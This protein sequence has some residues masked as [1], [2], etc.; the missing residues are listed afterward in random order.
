[1]KARVFLAAKTT[2]I[3][4]YI[5]PAK[6]DLRPDLCIF[7]AGTNEFSLHKENCEI[8]DGIV[9]AA[10]LLKSDQNTNT[11]HRIVCR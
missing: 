7:H 6:R 11:S 9:N 2:D 8:A 10:E 1:M 4:D 3:Q 5:K